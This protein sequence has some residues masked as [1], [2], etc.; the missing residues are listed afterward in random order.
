MFTE[1]VI[2]AKDEV[3]ELFILKEITFLTESDFKVA[4][5]NK[6]KEK[7]DSNITVNTESP[8]YDTYETNKTYY[9]DVTAFDKDKL[10]IT[11]DPELN[12]KGYK[13]DDE[14]LVIELKYFRYPTD[15]PKIAKDF[16]KTRLLIKAPKNECFIIASARTE[17]IFESA[18]EFMNEQLD[19]YRKEYN[20][21]VKIYL[22]GPK[23]VIEFE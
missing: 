1:K 14:A 5:S 15:I 12:R 11:Y 22:I 9:V 20:K 13:Y 10:Q 8:W 17:E 18:N 19:I 21:R 2:I 3:A 16:A 23:K 6:I 4:F 7:F